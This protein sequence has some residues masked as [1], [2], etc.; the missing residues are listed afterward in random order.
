MKTLTVLFSLFI[1]Q[2]FSQDWQSFYT[3]DFGETGLWC[4]G[5]S[6][7]SKHFKINHLDNKMWFAHTSQIYSIDTNGV[8]TVHNHQ[9]DSTLPEFNVSFAEF[10][11]ANNLVYTPD[12][13][14]GNVFSYDGNEW[15]EALSLPNADF[16][17]S[18][19]DTL[20]VCQSSG[21]VVTIEA[22]NPVA[23]AYGAG[24]VQS[25]NGEA[26]SSSGLGGGQFDQ[27]IRRYYKNT[28]YEFYSADTAAFLL[29]NANHDF[30]YA[31]NSDTLFTCGNR[32]FSLAYNHVF[33]DTITANNTTNMPALKIVEFEFD[34]NDNIWAL[35]G[36]DL[37][38]VDY[39]AYLDRS[40]NNWSQIYDA[41]NSPI[42]FGGKMTIEV[43]SKGNLY[44]M[45]FHVLKINNWPQWL[46]LDETNRISFNVYPN[47]ATKNLTISLS[48]NIVVDQY[49][50]VDL[51]GK[52]IVEKPFQSEINIDLQ[53]GT[54]FIQIIESNV[55]VGIQKFIVE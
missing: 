37:E 14:S 52:T 2:S 26:W 17:S 6:S 38:N 32:G 13:Y 53:S 41:N 45:Q 33:V 48:N 28:L 47:P 31:N 18:D 46:N 15:L 22:G 21:V 25:R 9:S 8:Y 10:A 43:D 23:N 20:W 35:F 44:V 39:V 24:K 29:D 5:G 12:V 40:T 7:A 36:A 55:V 51:T 54:Y 34:V 42:D 1:F 27:Y 30:K 50:I 4:G 16:V 49:K 19:G 11:F 3:S